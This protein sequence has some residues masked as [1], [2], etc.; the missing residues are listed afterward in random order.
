MKTGPWLC[1]KN[2]ADVRPHA[3]TWSGSETGEV[4]EAWAAGDFR[5]LPP[6]HEIF[7]LLGRYTAQGSPGVYLTL[8]NNPGNPRLR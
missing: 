8:R 1:G 3:A 7:H 2:N 5:L 6:L 4:S